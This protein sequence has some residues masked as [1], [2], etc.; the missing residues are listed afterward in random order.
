MGIIRL[1]GHRIK[2][3]IKGLG[4]WFI[5]LL[6]IYYTSINYRP[7]PIANWFRV[8]EGD[9]SAIYR[10]KIFTRIPRFFLKIVNDMIYEFENL[11]LTLLNEKWE[12]A[13]LKSMAIRTKNKRYEF[14]A[15]ELKTK[16][17]KKEKEL[18][19]QKTQTLNEFIDYIEL[20]LECTGTINPDKFGTGRAYSLYHKA[21]EKNKRLAEQYKKQ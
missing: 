7:I 8:K 19:N 10:F 20:T 3:K 15:N 4:D 1:F 11:D 12:A 5:K 9:L 14:L 21:V 2:E 16:I 6:P 17:E 18:N 13:R